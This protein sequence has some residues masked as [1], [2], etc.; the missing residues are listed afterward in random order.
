[1]IE[2]ILTLLTLLTLTIAAGA[3]AAFVGVAAYTYSTQH[4]Y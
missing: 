3:V 2:R 4:C 1:V